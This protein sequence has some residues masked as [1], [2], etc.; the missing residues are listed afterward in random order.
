MRVR[1]TGAAAGAET[2]QLYAVDPVAQVTRP[3][4]SLLAFAKVDLAP[5][6]QA[7]IRF[8]VHTDRLAFTGLAGRRIVEP[9][10]IVLH[11]GSSSRDTPVRASVE[12]VGEVRQLVTVRHHEL[13]VTVVR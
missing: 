13:P 1:D 7:H 8:D 2:V 11:A 4:R 5:G 10:E 3:V 9:G 6:E 12:L